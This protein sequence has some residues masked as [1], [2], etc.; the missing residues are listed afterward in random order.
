MHFMLILIM[1]PF[2]LADLSVF[3]EFGIRDGSQDKHG[4]CDKP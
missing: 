3:V 2:N 1:Y 4:P